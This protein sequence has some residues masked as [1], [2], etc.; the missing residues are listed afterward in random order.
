MGG[1]QFVLMV[2]INESVFTFKWDYYTNVLDGHHRD[3]LKADQSISKVSESVSPRQ[4]QNH[5]THIAMY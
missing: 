4:K 2:V 5:C 1:G 3:T